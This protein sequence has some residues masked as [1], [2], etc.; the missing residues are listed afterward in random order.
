MGFRIVMM[1]IG[2]I[3]R[4]A[5]SLLWNHQRR[6]WQLLALPVALTTLFALGEYWFLSDVPPKVSR[7]VGWLLK[8]TNLLIFSFFA[9][10]CHR[11]I[12]IGRHAVSESGT[13][14]WLR[15]EFKFFR[16]L[17]LITGFSVMGALVTNEAISGLVGAFIGEEFLEGQLVGS[18]RGLTITMPYWAML[19]LIPYG[20]LMGRLSLLLPAITV[21]LQPNLRSAWGQ[22]RG[23]G[24]Q[25]ALL[26]GLIPC[27]FFA[28]EITFFQYGSYRLLEKESASFGLAV[29]PVILAAGE[30]LLRYMLFTFEVAMLSLSFLK[31][32]GW[33]IDPVIP[34]AVSE[35]RS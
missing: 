13:S 25:M 22:S 3:I 10:A 29:Y 33:H 32:S 18:L 7:L 17:I 30:A 28:L 4:E 14:C 34:S 23:Y 5:V 27:V 15:R 8:L 12:L 2:S 11:F 20:Y 26:V 9:V 35:G 31:L 1:R 24:W 21:D 16:W 6:F 19:F